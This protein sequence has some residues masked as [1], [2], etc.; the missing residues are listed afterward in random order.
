MCSE[1]IMKNKIYWLMAG[2]G[3]LCAAADGGTLIQFIA[4]KV[5]AIGLLAIAWR[6]IEVYDDNL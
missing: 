2:V 3:F 5:I 4:I 1:G 6:N